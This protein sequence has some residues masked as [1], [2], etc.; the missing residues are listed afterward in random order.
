[1]PLQNRVDPFGILF[2]SPARGLFMG[3]RGGRIHDPATR[4][5]LKRRWASKQWICCLTTFKGR[6]RPVMGEGYTEL[7]FLDEVTALAAG[8]RPCFECRRADA[9]RF[10]D[11]LAP[12]TRAGDL[13]ALAHPMRLAGP[14]D[15]PSGP[16]PDGAMVAVDATAY[17]L[18]AE[19]FLRWSPFGYEA[20]VPAHEMPPFQLLTPQPF[21]GIVAAG[22]SPVW[23]ESADRLIGRRTS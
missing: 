9:R 3:N 17:A 2:A 10:A 19:L 14:R 5:L 13:D 23:H 8:H 4:T 18:K 7:F 22:Y 16:L 15:T 11:L 12:G 6:H 21:L 20:A 1:M